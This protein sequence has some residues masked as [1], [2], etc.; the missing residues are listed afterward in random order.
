MYMLNYVSA[1][2][3]VSLNGLLDILCFYNPATYRAARYY[4]IINVE[5]NRYFTDGLTQRLLSFNA[6]CLHAK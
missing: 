3:F 6:T 1:K 2:N 5:A 4:M